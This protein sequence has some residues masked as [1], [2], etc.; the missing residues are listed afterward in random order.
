MR[1]HWFPTAASIGAAAI[2]LRTANASP[3][4]DSVG[5]RESLALLLASEIAAM[6]TLLALA[7][8][9]C[10]AGVLLVYAFPVPRRDALLFIDMALMIGT[11]VVSAYVTIRLERHALVS[12]ILC[13]QEE[14]IQLSL[15]LI[16]ALAF[17]FVIIALSLLI[18]EVP[19]V[20]EWSGSYLGS[21]LK[22]VGGGR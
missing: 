13:D 7:L 11:A 5:A 18:A 15:S 21:L 10:F 22:L 19:G 12:R 3:P 16:R 14:G 1:S 6:R 2:F 17:P 4:V 20:R 9:S 8:L